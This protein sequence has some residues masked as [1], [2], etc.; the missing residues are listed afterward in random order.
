MQIW[1]NDIV[2]IK[3]NVTVQNSS[4]QCFNRPVVV[5]QNNIG[6]QHSPISYE[7]IGE[8]N[9]WMRIPSYGPK[10]VENIIQGIARDIL[11]EVMKRLEKEGYQ[12]VMHIHDEVVIEAP[13]D[14]S[15]DEICGIMGQSPDWAPG[16]LL[17]A[18]GYECEFYK[19]E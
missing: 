11:A 10:F 8:S 15:L 17:R 13:I 14:K 4:V 12:I 19:K 5:I 1:R 18:D 3:C 6:N 9:K 7:G 16:L 2:F